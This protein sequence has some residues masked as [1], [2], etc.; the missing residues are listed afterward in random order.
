MQMMDCR[1]DWN[2]IWMTEVNLTS[3]I[4]FLSNQLR[5]QWCTTIIGRNGSTPRVPDNLSAEPIGGNLGPTSVLMFPV[6]QK[7]SIKSASRSMKITNL[8][9]FWWSTKEDVIFLLFFFNGHRDTYPQPRGCEDEHPPTVLS[10]L[11]N[12]SLNYYI[13]IDTTWTVIKQSLI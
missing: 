4:I 13:T 2:V 7:W 10:V 11:V 12:G 9:V 1:N 5:R 8:L 3:K 6:D